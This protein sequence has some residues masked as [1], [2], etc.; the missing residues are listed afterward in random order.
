KF[1]GRGEDCWETREGEVLKSPE[2][3]TLCTEK[4]CVFFGHGFNGC[5]AQFW[6]NDYTEE[7]HTASFLDMM[8]DLE[9]MPEEGKVNEDGTW[10]PEAKKPPVP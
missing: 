7:E 9:D 1:E 3:E 4:D 6:A 8:K 10:E 2:F 5:L